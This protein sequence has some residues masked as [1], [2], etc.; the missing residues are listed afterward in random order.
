MCKGF[1]GQPC[2]PIGVT[3]HLPF[4]NQ[5]FVLARLRRDA[6]QIVQ[7]ER[8]P[9]DTR[10]LLFC[11][12][13]RALKR[14]CRGAPR[15]VRRRNGLQCRGMIRKRIHESRVFGRIKQRLMFVLT[16]Q[17]D[18]SRAKVAQSGRGGQRV[19]YECTAAALGGDFAPD[20]DRVRHV[21][22]GSFEDGLDGGGL[23]T[24]AD[25]V[26]T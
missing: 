7:L 16:V 14:A 2:Q 21:A 23:L 3:K 18:Q 19:V 13:P 11:A 17:V 4:L 6:I 20:N 15:F 5:C 8:D 26:C 24:G 25:K 1:G 9:L 22:A 10:G 12:E